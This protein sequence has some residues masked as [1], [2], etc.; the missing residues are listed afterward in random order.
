MGLGPHQHPVKGEG[1][2][3]SEGSQ[4]PTTPIINSRFIQKYGD[5]MK[6]REGKEK[7]FL[8]GSINHF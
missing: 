8:I 1:L 4:V 5:T 2:G 7:V 3:R 6:G